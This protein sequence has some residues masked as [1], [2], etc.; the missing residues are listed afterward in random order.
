MA[1]RCCRALVLDHPTKSPRRKPEDMVY[2]NL[3]HR[4]AVRLAG[5]RPLTVNPAL[6]AWRS[7]KKPPAEAGEHGVREPAASCRSSL[8]GPAPAD[9]QP[10]PPGL[11]LT[12][13]AP[14][15]SRGTPGG[16]PSRLLCDEGSHKWIG[17][18]PAAWTVGWFSSPES[19][20]FRPGL[21]GPARSRRPRRVHAQLA[22][23]GSPGWRAIAGEGN[24]GFPSACGS[25]PGPWMA[26]AVAPAHPFGPASACVRLAWMASH[27]RRGKPWL[28]L[29]LR[30][31]AGA[32]DGPAGATL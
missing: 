32:M 19:P 15:G 9:S 20:G 18:C 13:K 28:S 12:Q 24:L 3:R 30:K 17:G 27:R 21:L 6:R 23:L 1:G 31:P 26:D 2:A 8:G 11:A 29:R 25:P 4:A 7:H 22:P 10:G 16:I 14:G 5:L